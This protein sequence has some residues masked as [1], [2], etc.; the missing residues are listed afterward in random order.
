[1]IVSE[2]FS[3]TTCMQPKSRANQRPCTTTDASVANGDEMLTEG[4]KQDPKTRT[5]ELRTTTPEEALPVDESK[6]ASALILTDGSVGRVHFASNG[7][8]R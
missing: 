5:F 3:N 4:M 7:F 2:S 6:A 8:W 1:M